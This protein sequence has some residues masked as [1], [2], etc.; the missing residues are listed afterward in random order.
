MM[1]ANNS[2]SR[3]RITW[4]MPILAPIPKKSF[5]ASVSI[6]QPL[7]PKVFKSETF[8]LVTFPQGFWKS[9]K[10]GDWSSG[11]GGKKMFKQSEQMKQS[12]KNTFAS[13]RFLQPLWGK[14][15]KTETTFFPYFSLRLQEEGGK[16]PIIIVR[17]KCDG[18]T[19]RHTYGNF[20]LYKDRPKRLFDIF[21]NIFLIYFSWI[22]APAAAPDWSKV[23]KQEA[24]RAG[25]KIQSAE[26]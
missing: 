6:L 22:L 26:C 16:R 3:Q 25:N 5:F 21:L 19:H 1:S 15:F 8:L 7:W 17:K 13:R 12:V 14:V 18:Q 10:F 9:N 24:K 11:S 20:D 2:G 4:R 23:V